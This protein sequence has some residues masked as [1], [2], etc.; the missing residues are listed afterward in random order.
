M[1]RTLALLLT[2]ALAGCVN[3]PTDTSD[4][5]NQTQPTSP[6]M[7]ALPAPIEASEQVTGSAD[8]LNF[9][10]MPPCSSP[11]AQCFPYPFDLNGT[12]TIT[13]SL[14]W[15]VPASDFDLYIF[16]DGA[17]IDV[18]GQG[19]SPPQSAGTTEEA[20]EQELDEGAYEL[21]VV[22]WSVAQDTF[23]LSA[24]FTA[25]SAGNETAEDNT[26]FW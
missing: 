26:T 8:P 2:L 23:T 13:A 21:V 14:A 10:Q 3:T 22:A 6:G 16:Q 5:A 25:S 18:G 17:P 9:A 15:T 7:T 4:D 24:T 19:A 11:T 20:I 12:A 1:K